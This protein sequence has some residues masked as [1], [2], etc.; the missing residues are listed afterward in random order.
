MKIDDYLNFLI[1]KYGLEYQNN[2]QYDINKLIIKIMHSRIPNNC[3]IVIRGNSDR[4]AE[5]FITLLCNQF[6]IKCIMDDYTQKTEIMGIPVVSC[7]Y[8]NNYQN[9]YFLIGCYS[10]HFLIYRDRKSVV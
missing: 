3:S 9:C 1:K 2:F 8:I 6:E 7:D 10:K 5:E 4:H